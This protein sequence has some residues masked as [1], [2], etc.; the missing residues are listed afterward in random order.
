MDWGMEI[1]L[2]EEENDANRKNPG[3]I[4]PRTWPR[5]ILRLLRIDEL[6]RTTVLVLSFSL[7][8][9][10]P[11]RPLANRRQGRRLDGAGFLLQIRQHA[12]GKSSAVVRA[13]KFCYDALC[14]LLP[15][16]NHPANGIA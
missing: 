12:D 5:Q 15:R 8:S 11:G 3:A 2:Y 16:T 7:W 1:Q 14:C 6:L 9:T 10:R 4:F 13:L